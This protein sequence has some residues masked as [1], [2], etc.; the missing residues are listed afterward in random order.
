MK[1]VSDKGYSGV[2]NAI[3]PA[4]AP[5]TT[6]PTNGGGASAPVTTR[7]GGSGSGGMAPMTTTTPPRTSTRSTSSQTSQTTSSSGGSATTA[8]GQQTTRLAIC[9]ESIDS[10][11]PGGNLP[12]Q[13][14]GNVAS[15]TDCCNLCGKLF[16]MSIIDLLLIFK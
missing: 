7:P 14:R 9:V 1:I 15:Y 2:K 12:N 6:R 5:I 11:I 13:G 8:S 10:N 4:N 16:Y 3:A